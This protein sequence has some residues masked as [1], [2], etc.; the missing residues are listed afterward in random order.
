[1]HSLQHSSTRSRRYGPSFAHFLAVVGQEKYMSGMPI[2]VFQAGPRRGALANGDESR[3]GLVGIRP[4]R[5]TVQ[6]RGRSCTT[7]FY[8]YST[9]GSHRCR[10][11]KCGESAARIR[12]RRRSHH[13]GGA[14]WGS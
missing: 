2:V 8:I 11:A 12:R 13:R 4:E 6:P 3:R 9:G 5:L 14:K 7:R 1:M 10:R